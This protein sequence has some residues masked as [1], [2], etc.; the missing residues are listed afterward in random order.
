MMWRRWIHG[1]R[2]ITISERDQDALNY[3]FGKHKQ[4]ALEGQIDPLNLLIHDKAVVVV[5]STKHLGIEIAHSLDLN[6]LH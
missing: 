3:Y 1:S 5:Q 2:V 6:P 4:A